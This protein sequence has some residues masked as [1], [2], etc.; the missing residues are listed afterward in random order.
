MKGADLLLNGRRAGPFGLAISSTGAITASNFWASSE[1]NATNAWYVNFSTGNINGNN[2]FNA[3]V[4]RA[5]VALSEQVMEG[6]V[7]A[8]EDCCLHKM[9]TEQCL[10]YRLHAAEDLPV[11]A[12]EIEVLRTYEPGISICFIVTRPKLREIFAA[13]FRDRIAQ[14][15][16]CIRL[17]PFFE[18]RFQSMGNVSYNCRSGFGTAAA[19][20]RAEEEIRKVTKEYTE[21]AYIGTM[22]IWS[23]F[24]TIDKIVLW[25]LLEPFIRS[26]AHRIKELFPDTDIETL[27][28]LTKKTIMHAPQSNCERRGRIDLWDHLAFWKSLFNALEHIGMPIGNI[29]SQELANFLM[30]FLDEWAVEYCRGRGMSYIRFVDDIF[31]VATK[32]EDI[33]DFRKELMERLS[34]IFNQRLHPDKFYIQ[35]WRH[36]VK[37]VGRIIKHGRSYTSNRTVSGLDIRIHALE[38][39]CGRIV[40]EGI[41][42]Q[43][44]IELDSLVCAVNSSLG[45]FI[46]TASFNVRKKI[47]SRLR[48]FWKICYIVNAHVVKIKKPYKLKTILLQHE[49]NEYNGASSGRDGAQFFQTG[50]T[51]HQFRH[52]RTGR[53][54]REVCV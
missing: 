37:F 49:E 2:K 12:A 44:S 51:N 43:T 11:L 34:V 19:A 20:D 22:D 8:F 7:L 21:Q 40:R 4:A 9:S 23:F 16:I 50:G 27:I 38:E 6:W 18:E 36:G 5:V 31:V 35:R 42:I 17:R 46:R 53:R 25:N 47:F 15:W 29:T 14:H 32:K 24:M 39:L 54:G 28:W 45:F 1:Y 41:N 13:D 3:N 30:S 52:R 48:N 26:N 10:I 33:L